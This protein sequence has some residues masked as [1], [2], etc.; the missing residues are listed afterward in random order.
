MQTVV[1]VN[2]GGWGGLSAEKG[3]YDAFVETLREIVDRAERRSSSFSGETTYR[4]AEAH[5]TR[6]VEEV[7]KKLDGH[8]VLVFVTRGMLGEARRIKREYPNIRVVVLTGDIPDDDVIVV[9][10]RWI[11]SNEQL[12]R[13][14]LG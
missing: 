14:I 2:A 10:K 4:V 8:G 1:I 3:S 7:L 5:V 9:S 11:L 12:E 6:S 13:V